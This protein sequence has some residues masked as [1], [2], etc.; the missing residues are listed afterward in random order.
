MNSQIILGDALEELKKLQSQSVDLIITSPPY[1]NQRDYEVKNQLG[2]EETEN[3]Y[4]IL[5]NY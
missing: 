2:M 3:E 4:K 1:Y 5:A